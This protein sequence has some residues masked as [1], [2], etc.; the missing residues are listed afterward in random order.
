MSIV[1]SFKNASKHKYIKQK[2][3]IITAPKGKNAVNVLL[4]YHNYPGFTVV[5]PKQQKQQTTGV[6]TPY[7]WSAKTGRWLELRQVIPLSCPVPPSV[8]PNRLQEGSRWDHLWGLRQKTGTKG[9]M[10]TFSGSDKVSGLGYYLSVLV[11][12]S[13]SH[14]C[15]HISVYTICK[16]TP[17]HTYTHTH[18]HTH[19]PSS[20]KL[21]ETNWGN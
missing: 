3:P 19:L 16:H 20:L 8:A 13:Q 21:P 14:T 10:D 9:E 7:P 5:A 17:T 18:T 6:R 2:P 15:K 12:K 11:P 1:E 4:Y